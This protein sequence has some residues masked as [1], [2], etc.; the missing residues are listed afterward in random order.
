MLTLLLDEEAPGGAEFT[1]L[2]SAVA[3]GRRNDVLAAI[4][5]RAEA[6]A[7]LSREY[8]AG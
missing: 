7:R 5:Q 6:L 4:R 8:G 3:P 2:L 1:E